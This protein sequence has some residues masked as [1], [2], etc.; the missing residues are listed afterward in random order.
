MA[1]RP[2]TA[3]TR[4]GK[5]MSNAESKQRRQTG[6]RNQDVA[7]EYDDDYGDDEFDDDF[8]DDFEDLDPTFD[9]VLKGQDF[10][11]Q[12][13]E[14][15]AKEDSGKISSIPQSKMTAGLRHQMASKPAS[16][17]WLVER[18]YV[19][20][21]VISEEERVY[22]QRQKERVDRI[23]G[24]VE[25]SFESFDILR[26]DPEPPMQRHMRNVARGLVRD[27]S[28]Q[29]NDDWRSVKIQTEH[30]KTSIIS[31]Q[32][33]RRLFE[34]SIVT[35]A[36]AARLP[37]FVFRASQVVEA[38]ILELNQGGFWA[39]PNN[40]SPSLQTG[41]SPFSQDTMMLT[42]PHF[43]GDRKVRS[44]HFS[45]EVSNLL[46]VAYS[47]AREDSNI[48]N[49]RAKE[50]SPSKMQVVDPKEWARTV[51]PSKAL[52]CLW[53]LNQPETPAK[54]MYCDGDVTCCGLS[55]RGLIAFAGLR[56]GS[57]V[58]WDLREKSML[59]RTIDAKTG[60]NFILRHPSYSTDNFISK[61]HVYPVRKVVAVPRVG[62]GASKVERK[63]ERT[64]NAP[65]NFQIIS[66]DD[67]SNTKIWTVLE[68]QQGDVAGSES[69][70]GLNL[71]SRM[72]LI[73]SNDMI[74]GGQL[75]DRVATDLH[76]NP[77][78]PGEVMIAL[79]SGIVCRCRRFG[80]QPS[81]KSYFALEEQ[82]FQEEL[83]APVMCKDEWG[84]SWELLPVD[85]GESSRSNPPRITRLMSTGGTIR[86][87]TKDQTTSSIFL[88]HPPSC[89]RRD[90]CTSMSISPFKSNYFLVAYQSGQVC[91]FIKSLA[92]PLKVWSSFAT[93]S[94]VEIRW[95]P[96]RPSVFYALDDNGRF[97]SFDLLKNDQGPVTET[98]LK[99]ATRG[100]GKASCFEIS[101]HPDRGGM[102]PHLTSR[103]TLAYSD[104]AKGTVTLCGIS[105]MH[106]LLVKSEILDF[107]AVLATLS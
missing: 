58:L 12:D 50:T 18:N 52:L 65:T 33:P 10:L 19:P 105:S 66:I 24:D 71:G 22:M 75:Q 96:F 6:D 100:A 90:G 91:L 49:T 30:P 83:E 59:H 46:L 42:L 47:K 5:L 64:C 32:I 56:E 97:F 35:E 25:L 102:H 3:T 80:A 23:L 89:A 81:P 38:L 4:Q 29:Y 27:V 63:G 87:S 101:C 36:S 70:F 104:N 72:K 44:L 21:R 93:G 1:N 92:H 28:T 15:Q 16:S 53:Y 39:A 103:P 7:E 95:S 82:A 77:S 78:D 106:S 17:E 11:G 69:D 20:K 41:S 55:S 86:S 51:L 2:S 8:E 31:T 13:T 67:S 45:T 85:T 73:L 68:L 88:S 54:I 99:K 43:F 60:S 37:D 14:A 26:R 48:D 40:T 107:E 62:S 34:G 98:E 74:A 94:L 61:N 84:F 79:G 9:K 76:C 57:V